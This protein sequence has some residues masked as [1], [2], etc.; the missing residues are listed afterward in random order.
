M[1]ADGRTLRGDVFLDPVSRFRAE[2]QQP[3]EFFNSDERFF[4][5]DTEAMAVLVNKDAVAR[6]VTS[7]PDAETDDALDVA[8]V[9]VSVEI[10]LVGGALCKGWIFPDNHAGRARLIDFLNSYASRFFVVYDAEK[11]TLVNRSAVTNVWEMA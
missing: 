11:L 2:P 7:L 5:L 6:A 1:F 3:D 8:R 10:A 4:V 9:G